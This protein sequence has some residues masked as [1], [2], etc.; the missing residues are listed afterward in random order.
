MKTIAVSL[1][2]SFFA[3]VLAAAT[4]PDFTGSWQFAPKQSKNIGMMAGM[5]ML[6]T[7]TQT[8]GNVTVTYDVSPTDR[9]IMRFDLSGKS[10]DNPTQMGGRAQT[11][12]ALTDKELVTLW[13][14]EGAVAGTTVTRTETWA[15]SPEGKLLTI[16]SVRGKNTPVVMVFE[17]RQ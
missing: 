7:I 17:K 12:S 3:V 1:I 8:A 15:L 9:T 16:T 13:T 10:V 5:S 2:V 14:T 4:K 11:T 6:A